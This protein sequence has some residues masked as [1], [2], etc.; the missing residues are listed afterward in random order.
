M[1]YSTSKEVDVIVR[2]YIKRKWRYKRGKKHGLLY[3][4]NCGLFIVVPGSPSDSLA[5]FIFSQEIR[6]LERRVQI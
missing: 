6:R 4:P 2:K 3:P 5:G 1:K